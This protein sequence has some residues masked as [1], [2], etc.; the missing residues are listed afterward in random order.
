MEVDIRAVKSGHDAGKVLS[1]YRF[2]IDESVYNYFTPE[3]SVYLNAELEKY[4]LYER[5]FIGRPCEFELT[6][7]IEGFS[8][9]MNVLNNNTN[10]I[11][12]FRFVFN[13]NSINFFTAFRKV[14]DTFEH[15]SD[16]RRSLCAASP[17]ITCAIFLEF[18]DKCIDK[19]HSM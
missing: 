6:S 19:L 1:D 18:V 15:F 11:E 8:H 3:R 14:N 2:C 5:Y 9:T 7:L 10:R 16:A 12:V 13:P 17:P 4:C